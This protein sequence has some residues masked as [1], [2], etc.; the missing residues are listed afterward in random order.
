MFYIFQP[1]RLFKPFFLAE[2]HESSI[3][4]SVDVVVVLQSAMAEAVAPKKR[5][6]LQAAVSCRMSLGSNM[7]L[8]LALASL[9]LL[10]L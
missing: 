8:S 2:S 1:V 3:H 4:S 9:C 7:L 10:R 6:T 5:V